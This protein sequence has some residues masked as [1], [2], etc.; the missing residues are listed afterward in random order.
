MAQLEHQAERYARLSEI[1]S[2]NFQSWGSFWVFWWLF[3]CRAL[4]G[5]CYARGIKVVLR[6][7]KLL[8]QKWPD[9]QQV[10]L[11]SQRLHVH[12]SSIK[13]GCPKLECINALLNSSRD[14]LFEQ[15]IL[16][17]DSTRMTLQLE[18]CISKIISKYFFQNW[19]FGAV[20]SV[21]RCSMEDSQW[22]FNKNISSATEEAY[23]HQVIFLH[24]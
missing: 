14:N 11:M 9:T 3:L 21:W 5:R 13:T 16:K 8:V 6:W 1:Q 12:A 24:F 23:G 7:L 10:T 17:L 20:I 4:I 15:K 22:N 19:K 18:P 2:S